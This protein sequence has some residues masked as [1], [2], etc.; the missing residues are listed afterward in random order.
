MR[1]AV[2]CPGNWA[3]NNNHVHAIITALMDAT[4]DRILAAYFVPERAGGSGRPQTWHITR[5]LTMST[6]DPRVKRLDEEEINELMKDTETWLQNRTNQV[7]RV[8]NGLEE[9]LRRRVDGGIA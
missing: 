2:I 8:R 5:E 1:I 9:I 6:E 3:V 7:D 4:E